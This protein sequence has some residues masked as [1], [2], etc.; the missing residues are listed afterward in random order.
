MSL[1]CT[2]ENNA[3]HVEDEEGI[4]RGHAFTSAV[5][6]DFGALLVPPHISPFLHVHL[7]SGAAED[8]DFLDQ[9]ALL[10]SGIH[11]WNRQWMPPSSQRVGSNAL[12]FVAMV[13]PPRLPSLLLS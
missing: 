13:F 5:G 1:I 10:N 6:R 4:F 8:Q 7:P 12:A 3:A 11:D 2:F 9:W